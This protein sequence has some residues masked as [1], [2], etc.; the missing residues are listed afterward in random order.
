MVT[1]IKIDLSDSDREAIALLVTGKKSLA[2]RKQINDFV[3]KTIA[4][5]MNPTSSGPKT[6]KNF[7]C[8][9]CNKPIALAVPTAEPA[10]VASAPAPSPALVT[11]S[12]DTETTAVVAALTALKKALAD[13]K[14]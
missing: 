5:A 9:K 1:N 11:K 6:L 3:V 7:V 13:F 4:A 14:L 10:V 12:P 2:T 8:P